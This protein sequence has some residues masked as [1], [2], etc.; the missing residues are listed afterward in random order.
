MKRKEETTLMLFYKPYLS[1][2][3][4]GFEIL[5]DISKGKALPKPIGRLNQE[6]V[7]LKQRLKLKTRQLNY[8]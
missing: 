3:R 5:V 6:P 2:R 1:P 7:R 8:E 4:E